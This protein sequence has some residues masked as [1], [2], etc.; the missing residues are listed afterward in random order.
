MNNLKK[1]EF[2]KISLKKIHIVFNKNKI[3]E[4]ISLLVKV[5]QNL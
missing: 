3:A 4:L 2:E 1:F 5:E